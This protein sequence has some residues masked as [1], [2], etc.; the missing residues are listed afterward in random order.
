MDQIYKYFKANHTGTKTFISYLISEL[1]SLSTIS[2]N[3]EVV[4]DKM[5][6]LDC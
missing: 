2:H 6:N 5:N 1:G 4:K 3:S